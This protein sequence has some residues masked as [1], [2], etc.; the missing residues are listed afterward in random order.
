MASREGEEKMTKKT[1]TAIELYQCPGCVCRSYPE[2]YQKGD[3]IECG[4][5]VVGTTGISIGKILLG[6]PRGFDRVGDV[7]H[8]Q[9]SIYE[10]HESSDWKYNKFNI[11]VWKHYDKNGNTLIR[12]MQPRIN[13]TF[14]HIFLEDCRNIIDCLEISQDDI[15]GMD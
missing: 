10:T 13:Q 11:P 9:L 2:C 3:G 6:M 4:K 15:N 7:N 8:L 12:G 1:K 5:H 14:I